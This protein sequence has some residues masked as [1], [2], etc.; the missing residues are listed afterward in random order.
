[1]EYVFFSR[2]WIRLSC[3]VPG[4]SSS[5]NTTTTCSVADVVFVPKCH[6]RIRSRSIVR[7]RVFRQHGVLVPPISIDP[8][9]NDFVYGEV[10]RGYFFFLACFRLLIIRMPNCSVISVSLVGRVLGGIGFRLSHFCASSQSWRSDQV[11]FIG[12]FMCWVV[13]FVFEWLEEVGNLFLRPRLRREDSTRAR[14]AFVNT[15]LIRLRR[16]RER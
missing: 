13:K 5:C 4:V 9:M 14:N 16:V 7:D 6:G 10:L 1:M 12:G 11:G 3:R 15:R 2:R 8:V